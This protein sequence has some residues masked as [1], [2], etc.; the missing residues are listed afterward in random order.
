MATLGRSGKPFSWGIAQDKVSQKSPGPRPPSGDSSPRLTIPVGE[1]VEK[2]I[3][4][5]ISYFDVWEDIIML[6]PHLPVHRTHLPSQDCFQ[7]WA[8]L[9]LAQAL[10]QKALVNLPCSLS[11]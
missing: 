6:K 2:E 11:P 8:V 1:T 7:V 4:F 3:F 10:T 9:G 5:F